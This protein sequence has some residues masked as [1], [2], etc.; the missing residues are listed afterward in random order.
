MLPEETSS[1]PKR[2]NKFQEL[3]GGFPGVAESRD[4]RMIPK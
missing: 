3:K 2:K 4:E 1:N